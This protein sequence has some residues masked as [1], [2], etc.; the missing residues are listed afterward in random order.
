MALKHIILL[1]V[2]VEIL[3][4]NIVEGLPDIDCN[5]LSPAIGEPQQVTVPYQVDISDLQDAEGKLSY[6]PERTYKCE[7]HHPAKLTIKKT[8]SLS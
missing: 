3:H 4:W 8:L 5:S 6:I 7:L 1:L 2:L